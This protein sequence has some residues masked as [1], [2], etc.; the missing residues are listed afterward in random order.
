MYKRQI[1]I[2]VDQSAPAGGDGSSWATAFNTIQDA[3]DAA[4]AND[5]ILIAAGIYQPQIEIDITIPLTIKGG[6][7]QGG[8]TQDIAANITQIQGDFNAPT[9]IFRI[10]HI[11]EDSDC[12]FQ[13]IRFENYGDGIYTDSNII[14]DQVQFIGGEGFDIRIDDV[15]TACA[16]TNSLFSGNAESSISVGGIN[17]FD[18]MTIT[19]SRFING[20]HKAIEVNQD[21]SNIS[22]VDCEI[23]GFDT[24]RNILDIDTPNVNILNLNAENNTIVGSSSILS[25][26]NLNGTVFIKDSN[27]SNNTGENSINISMNGG[28]LTVEDTDFNDNIINNS[29]FPYAVMNATRANVIARNCKVVNN[30]VNGSQARI[31]G[32]RSFEASITALIEN[33]EFTNNSGDGAIENLFRVSGDTDLTINNSIFDNNALESELVTDNNATITNNIFRNQ[34]AN[35]LVFELDGELDSDVIFENNRFH[36]NTNANF[37]I[38]NFGSLTSRSN[39]FTEN[40]RFTILNIPTASL[41]NE[42]SSGDNSGDSFLNLIGTNASIE[43]SIFISERPSG[44]HELVSSGNDTSLNI[45]NSTFSSSNIADTH[46]T[47]DF[48]NDVPSTFRNSIIWSGSNLAQSGFAGSTS[49]LTVRYS[50]IK[51]VN[52]TGAG[53]LNGTLAIN[54]PEFVNPDEFDFRMLDCSP[55]VNAGLNTYSN[56]SL[57][58]LGGTR[59]FETTIDMGAYELQ[60][61]ASVACTP[62]LLYTSPSPRD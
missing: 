23:T 50:L 3:V 56:E 25:Y 35:N 62:C 14:I 34:V 6:Y 51:G 57:D 44:V 12:F 11:S 1:D 9:L 4:S 19:N 15:I 42:Y 13:G 53:N 8:G 37:V 28:S 26:N 24:S 38:R 54:T 29:S 55:T 27:F 58:L 21:S 61:P 48:D 45:V 31:F 7:P 32:I 33:C 41:T 10:F 39:T 16:I 59:I 17:S 49:N 43:N 46:V 36:D 18:T 47:V 30:Y 52:P 40:V 5:T 60:I 22:I 2:Y 20:T